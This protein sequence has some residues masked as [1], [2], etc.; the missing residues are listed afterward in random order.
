MEKEYNEGI[1]NKDAQ[2]VS[3]FNVYKAMTGF[4][5]EKNICKQFEI[6]NQNIEKEI[7]GEKYFHVTPEEIKI[8]EEKTKYSDV[9]LAP[10]YMT[11]FDLQ[12]VLSFK[13]YVD[14]KHNDEIYIANS[15]CM[16]YGIKAIKKRIIDGHT[17][18]NVTEEDIQKIENATKKEKVLLKKKYEEIELNEEIKPAEYLFMYCY[19]MDT[20]KIYV[21]RNVYELCKKSNIEIEGNPKLIDGNNYYS[22]TEKQLETLEEESSYRGVE[23]LTKPSRIRRKN[24][25]RIIAYHDRKNNKYYIPIKYKTN[26]DKEEKVIANKFCKETT[27][28]ELEKIYNK[29]IIIAPV[30]PVIA[31]DYNILVC[32]NENN[33]LYVS[34]NV[35]EELKVTPEKKHKIIINKEVYVEISREELEAIRNKDSKSLNIIV[36]LKR[37]VPAKRG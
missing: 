13:V 16:K 9:R 32:C 22:I 29:R 1:E 37:I 4:F 34:K 33:E 23:K 25:N 6:G 5:V 26:E 7:N 36:R 20:K 21:P 28:Q 31:K 12:L 3:Y 14:K 18:C 2:K 27:L 35:L 24:E 15:L 11:F 10:H 8:I 17:Y 19:D 30:Y